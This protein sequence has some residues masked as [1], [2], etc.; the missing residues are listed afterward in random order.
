MYIMNVK[1]I[2]LSSFLAVFI[3]ATTFA[4]VI[5]PKIFSDNMV[6]QRETP[7]KLWG[8]AN[9]NARVA[10]EFAGQKKMTK[11]DSEGKWVLILDS[12]SVSKEPLEMQFYENGKPD[13][14]LGNILVGEVWITSGQSNMEWHLRNTTDAQEA[15]KRASE[16]KNIRVFRQK[17]PAMSLTKSWDSPDD[18]KWLEKADGKVSA[19]GYYFGEILMKELDMPI[20]LIDTALGGSTMRAWI[21]EE[22]FGENEFLTEYLTAF[23]EKVKNYDY[24]KAE[25]AWL[26]QKKKY[27]DDI[28]KAKKEGRTPPSIPW[29]FSRKRPNPISPERAQETPCGLYN[30]KIAP[31]AEFAIRGVIWYQGCSDAGGKSLENF[32]QQFVIMVDSWRKAWNNEN[33]Y[34]LWTNLASFGTKADWGKVRW[35]Q[36]QAADK[37]KNANVINIVDAGEEK[38]IHPKD[39]TTVG[40]RMANLALKEC[41]GFDKLNPYAPVLKNVK[42]SPRGVEVIFDFKGRKLAK[43]GN[44]AGFEV[45]LDGKWV[46]ATAEL[47]GRRIIVKPVEGKASDV[48]GVR[49]LWKSWALPEVWLF[50]NDGLPAFPFTNERP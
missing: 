8:K 12:L 19:V 40:T 41:Y 45:K 49:Y 32:E 11:A 21:P 25:Q 17:V 2:A 10:V 7:I 20:G 16:N 42:Y 36:F 23:K 3:S 33:I 37:I 14:K 6:L 44:P 9:A 4:E 43:K 22:R 5:L 24:K 35:A 48:T 28:A 18:A 50:N 31:I 26:E 47:L 1:K 39:K 29:N 13:K 46:P 30:A 38:D 15:L 34:F 27:D